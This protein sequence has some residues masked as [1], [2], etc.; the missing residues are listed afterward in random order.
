MVIDNDS[1][2]GESPSQI[3]ESRGISSENIAFVWN[4]KKLS[5]DKTFRDQGVKIKDTIYIVTN[6]P[7]APHNHPNVEKGAIEDTIKPNENNN[8]LM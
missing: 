6:D 5:L 1:Q 3:I 4:G 7:P 2:L 8:Y